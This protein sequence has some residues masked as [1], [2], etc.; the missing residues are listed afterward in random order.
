MPG[1]RDVDLIGHVREI[2]GPTADELTPDAISDIASQNYEWEPVRG[3][4]QPS[5]SPDEFWASVE[6]AQTA[7]ADSDA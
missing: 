6:R 3:V 1:I 4:F 7:A 5:T 2:I